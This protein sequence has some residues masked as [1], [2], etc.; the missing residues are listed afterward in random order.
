MSRFN[1]KSKNDFYAKQFRQ[2]LLSLRHD[3][4]EKF[5]DYFWSSNEKVMFGRR[6]EIALML[7]NK[8]TYTSITAKHD[9][10]PDTI[11]QVRLW[12]EGAGRF[13]R[14][15]MSISRHRRNTSVINGPAI[16]SEFQKFIKKYPARNALI[17]LML[18]KK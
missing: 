8:Q 3:E 11:R 18:K 5:C 1:N 12:L 2:F 13:S 9:V 7:L 6:V 4:L 15:R 17:K 14:A 16:E 10:S